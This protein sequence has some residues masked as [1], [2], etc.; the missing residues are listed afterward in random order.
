MDR[1]WLKDEGF[2]GPEH[3]MMSWFE[4]PL[5]GGHKAVVDAVIREEWQSVAYDERRPRT[6]PKAQGYTVTG[7]IVNAD[8]ASVGK[9]HRDVVYDPA[10][11]AVTVT[12]E[13]LM[14]DK[15]VH[16]QGIADAFN[17]HAVAKYQ[18]YGVSEIRVHAGST[19]GGYAWARQGFR[20]SP[21]EDRH[22]RVAEMLTSAQYQLH[23][24]AH[25]LGREATS[26]I[27]QEI[28]ALKAANDAG[29]DVQP[30]H[31]A[32]LGERVRQWTQIKSTEDHDHEYRTWLGKEALLGASW[33][34]H[35][36][37]EPGR[38]VVGSVS[39][40]AHAHVRAA[41]GASPELF[42]ALEARFGFVTVPEDEEEPAQGY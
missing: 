38:P 26:A 13:S 34:G 6:V 22:I 15:K 16:G 12:H 36:I 9:F 37:L 5:P 3:F 4:G 32:A 11:R 7:D 19:V 17:A 14:L 21:E 41:Y 10:T 30:I 42:A 28:K 20:I 40:L 1:E 8:G 24:E 27:Q 29:E 25:H 35:Y 18:E 23:A 33:M 2:D 31:V 39:D